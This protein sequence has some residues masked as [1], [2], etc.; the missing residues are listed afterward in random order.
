MGGT[1]K[2][3]PPQNLAASAL[4]NLSCPVQA[5]ICATIAYGF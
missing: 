3:D 1:F 2:A 4:L 5:L